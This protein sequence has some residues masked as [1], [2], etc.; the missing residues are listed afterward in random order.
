MEFINKIVEFVMSPWGSFVVALL[1]FIL[2]EAM[3]LVPSWKSS[4][5]V[6]FIIKALTALKKKQDENKNG[7]A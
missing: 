6:D 4:G 2:S 1:L 3:A 7:V 5:I